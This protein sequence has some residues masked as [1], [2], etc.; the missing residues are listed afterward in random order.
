MSTKMAQET[1]EMA[2]NVE[3]IQNVDEIYK[4]NRQQQQDILSAKPWEKE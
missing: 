4:Y 1:W 2:N 3:Q